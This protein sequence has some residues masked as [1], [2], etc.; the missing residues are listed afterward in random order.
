LLSEDAGPETWGNDAALNY[1]IR[2]F[3]QAKARFLWNGSVFTI[4]ISMGGLP[5]TLTAYRQTLGIPVKAIA[6]IAGRVNL[7]DAFVGPKD[8]SADIDSAYGTSFY[9]SQEYAHDPIADFYSYI[10]NKTP[11]LAIVSAQDDTVN[12][13]TNGELLVNLSK[14]LG[15]ESNIYSV[16]GPHLGS[17][18]LSV[19]VASKIASFFNLHQ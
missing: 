10:G 8:R 12:S 9:T 1:I 11:V 14:K 15:V 2:M 5:A 16:E 17:G 13:K 4:G 6:L 3:K 18:Y 19:D 7:L